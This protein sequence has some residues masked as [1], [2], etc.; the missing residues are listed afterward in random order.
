[1]KLREFL[2]DSGQSLTGF[3]EKVG[4]SEVSMGR[5]A[6]GK[7]LPRPKILR[8]IVAASGG[9]VEANDF[10]AP[11]EPTGQAPGAPGAAE[12]RPGQR[13]LTPGTV[14]IDMLF[15]DISGILPG[16]R[17]TPAMLDKLFS[18]GV[19]MPASIYAVDVT[20][21]NVDAS[22]VGM[23]D[24][25]PDAICRPLPGTLVPVPWAERPNA[26]VLT[27]MYRGDGRPHPLDPRHVLAR[28]AGRL[29]ELG[30]HPVMAHE[31]EFYLLDGEPGAD[32]APR[33]AVSSVDGRRPSAIGVYGMDE[34]DD[35]SALV[36]GVVA[37]CAAQTIPAT[38]VSAEYAPG[39]YEI[40]L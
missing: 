25:D 26:Q 18:Q 7:R 4:V 10:F 3:A 12:T 1:M 22:G 36:D 39:Q 19:T 8:R 38:V 32:G 37:A 16:K 31:L 11:A 5:Y 29:G 14:A 27:S 17:L 30:L 21:G 28:V 34:I 35:A 20:G 23:P 15:G 40:N 2:A 33:L 13:P 6:A 9:A 24:G